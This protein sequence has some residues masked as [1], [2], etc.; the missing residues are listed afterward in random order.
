MLNF[1]RVSYKVLATAGV[2]LLLLSAVLF[3]QSCADDDTVPAADDDTVPAAD[4][5]TVPAADDGNVFFVGPDDDTIPTVA[6]KRDTI[7]INEGS[8]NP[9]INFVLGEDALQLCLVDGDDVEI[10][11]N[12]R[13]GK[14]DG[15]SIYIYFLKISFND[16]DDPSSKGTVELRFA[17]EST[18]AQEG[19]IHHQSDLDDLLEE[20]T[21]DCEGVPA[22]SDCKSGSTKDDYETCCP[23]EDKIASDNLLACYL[24]IISIA[25][26][27]QLSGGKPSKI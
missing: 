13:E 26:P 15:S 5:D 21:Y 2:L 20:I 23:D 9:T 24:E 12:V 1:I 19:L 16:A 22:D 18:V 7:I 4:D 11:F 27:F 25:W 10:S 6:G 3:L 17:E 14:K 8:G